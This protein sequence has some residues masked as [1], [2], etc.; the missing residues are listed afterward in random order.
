M[1]TKT[2][3]KK[4]A[5][6]SQ[7]KNNGVFEEIAR[8]VEAAKA[9]KL[10]TRANVD[11]FD[12]P[13]RMMLEGVNG[14]LD[15]VIGPLNVAAEYVDRISKGDIPAKITDNYN[16]DFNELKNNLNAC[17]GAVN[18]LVA[19]AGVLAKA[20]VEG[21]LAT[22]ADA[23]KHQGD[24]RKIVQGVDDCL[25]A[26]I[27]PLN[28]AARYVDD[29]S[30]GNIPAKITDTYNGDFNTIKGN[31]NQCIDVM[32]G[33]LAETGTLIQ[34]IQDGKLQTRGNASAFPG[35]W[36]K[37]V[38]GVNNLTEAFI[39]PINETARIMTA[40]A[41]KDI[42]TRVT[43]EYKGE[44]GDLKGNLNKA[45]IALDEAL[46]QVS[47]AVEQVASAS[48]QISS[49]SQSLAQGTSEQAAAIEET[50]SSVEEMAS[51]TKQN[52]ANA[53]EAK[54][55][56]AGVKNS[57]EK[58]VQAMGRMSQAIDDIKKSSDKTA[59]IIK[60][61]DEIA[62]QTNLLALNAAVEAARAGEAG[63]GFAVVAEEVRNLAQRSAEAA[64]NTADMI[65]E[66]VKN[67]NNGV[68]ISKEVGESLEEI[69]QAVRK[70]NDL[71]GEITAAS[72]EQAQGI[73]QISTAIAQMDAVTQQNAANAEESASA[74]EELNAQAAELGA[75]T[76]KFSLTQTASGGGAHV[77][78]KHD[79]HFTH[80]A[81]KP[82]T[83]TK[84]AGAKKVSSHS[85][86]IQA[87]PATWHGEGKAK[88]GVEVIPMEGQ[89]ELAKF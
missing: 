69:G 15:A 21:K 82:A 51:M 73:D 23:S 64:K 43:D 59:K 57:T 78:K 66:S 33:L 86:K 10:N 37:L 35:G 52:A 76:A 26:V 4:S 32:N 12:G 55:L 47:T 34:A 25:D 38:G 67:A 85:Q 87:K 24:F 14:M 28:V 41:N 1:A 46:S 63:K 45:S 22:R 77:A 54:N 48:G 3:A 88:A 9:G 65:E 36:G 11:Q 31:L 58:G 44:F 18:E 70:V 2:M 42:T 20:A 5:T 16:G 68:V 62:F 40:M 53:N 8:L 39:R 72:N 50:T 56:T 13:N 74:A 7:S 80:D 27:G 17:I 75:M 84:A 60:T 89:E 71:V 29:I 49:A 19:D 61:I 30:K 6:V 83:A 79:L 81:G